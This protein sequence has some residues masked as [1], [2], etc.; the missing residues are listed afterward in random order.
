MFCNSC[1]EELP[2]G[3][4][5]CPVC[6][7]EVEETEEE[8]IMDEEQWEERVRYLKG[9]TGI[10]QK[11]LLLQKIFLWIQIGV[12]G[13]DIIRTL[14]LSSYLK[15]SGSRSARFVNSLFEKSEYILGFAR[16][17][18]LILILLELVYY[19]ELKQFERGFW[20]VAISCIVM[21][22]LYNMAEFKTLI[23]GKTGEI[24]YLLQNIAGTVAYVWFLHK[25]M[26]E[27]TEP[28][29]VKTSVRWNY[30]FP[31]YAALSA[32]AAILIIVF[33]ITSENWLIQSMGDAWI[34]CSLSLILQ[35]MLFLLLK[36]TVKNF[37]E[38]EV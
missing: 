8:D 14:G 20:Q 35:I 25:V 37:K 36:D 11:N 15:N 29:D 19:V 22:T 26:A 32:I 33:K 6:G 16:L 28:V 27:L 24:E 12:L 17:A 18:C 7:A 23:G 9:A 21:V 34:T 30:L 5:I 1:G 31:A 4:T 3:M 2:E 10:L 38:I 13:I